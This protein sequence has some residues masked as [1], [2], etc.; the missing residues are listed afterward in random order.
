MTTKKKEAKK[1]K[2]LVI[3]WLGYVFLVLSALLLVLSVNVLWVRSTI[4]DTK[5]W[6]DRAVEIISD[7]DVRQDLSARITA[8]LYEEANLDEQISDVL[9]ERARPIAAAIAEASRDFTEKKIYEFLG[10]DAF[11]DLWRDLQTQAHE[12]FIEAIER[13]TTAATDE[14]RQDVFY[15]D[16]EILVLNIRPLLDN[17]ANNLEEAGVGFVPETQLLNDEQTTIVIAEV[18][19]LSVVTTSFYVLD[20]LGFWLPT[21]TVIIGGIGLWL[22][23]NKRRALG[24]VSILAIAIAM[25]N[26]QVVRLGYELGSSGAGIVGIS[27]V[28]SQTMYDILTSAVVTSL[29]T[30][31]IVLA[32]IL[33][34]LFATTI[35]NKRKLERLMRQPLNYLDNKQLAWLKKN[36][37]ILIIAIG[38]FTL[39]LLVTTSFTSAIWPILIILVGGGTI[40]V[41]YIVK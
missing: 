20:K 30:L 38:I 10:S 33:F 40:S 2:N 11:I 39:L 28:S 36:R 9:P 37:T 25:V 17:I 27:G 14:T 6:T 13:T 18:N 1:A 34:F 12:A 8:A 16:D 31:I 23:K 26:L 21:A 32:I 15:F 3:S 35:R 24:F 4:L 22:A 19:N 5:T 7:E 29:T 41:I